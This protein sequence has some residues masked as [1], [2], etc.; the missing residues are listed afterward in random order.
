MSE[1]QQPAATDWTDDPEVMATALRCTQ[2]LRGFAVLNATLTEG[3]GA[4]AP[5]DSWPMQGQLMALSALLVNAGL[6]TEREVVLATLDCQASILEG[7]L[8]AAAEA[9]RQRTGII[10]PGVFPLNGGQQG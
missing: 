8:Q 6:L 3:E 5:M 4:Y 10:I 9:K 7:S 1:E 2:A